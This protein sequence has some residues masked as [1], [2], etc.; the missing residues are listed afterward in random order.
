VTTSFRVKQIRQSAGLFAVLLTAINVKADSV[1]LRIDDA[2]AMAI[3]GSSGLA[4]METRVSALR[5]RPAQVKALADPMLSINAMSLPVDTFDTDQEPMTQLQIALSQ[6]LPFPGKRALKE[7]IAETAVSEQEFQVAEKSQQIAGR[8]RS[9]WWQ[10]HAEEKALSIISDN[11]ALL[12]D[13]IEITRAKYAVGKG[14]QQDVLLAELELNR[15]LDRELKVSG[16]RDAISARLASLVNLP[17]GSTITTISTLNSQDFQDLPE[18]TSVEQLS[19][20]GAQSRKLLAAYRQ[21]IIAAGKRVDLAEKDRYPDFRVGVGYGLRDGENAAG[22]SRPDFLSVMFS[23]NL[24]IYAAGKQDRL[25]EQRFLEKQQ[26]QHQL[27]DA[28][29]Q[30]ASEIGVL[31]SEYSTAR[32]QAALLQ[33]NII[34]QADQTVKAMMAGYQVNKVDFLNVV[35]GQIMLYNAQINY[36]NSLARAKSAL[37]KLAAVVGR[38][39]LYE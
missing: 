3:S 13:F 23:M 21:R 1:K 17:P 25:V 11:R 36:W 32:Q 38:E 4:A 16:L 2:V 14:L 12:S 15:L 9:L 8:V 37:A 28:L 22:D 29:Q 33:D 30:M 10:L 34:P 7:E 31:Y 19:A 20:L 24:P 35:N 27:D 5:T 6:P 26:Q 18:L 39:S